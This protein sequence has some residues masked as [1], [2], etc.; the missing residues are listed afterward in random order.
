M[1]FSLVD[2][3]IKKLQTAMKP[4]KVRAIFVG[5]DVHYLLK[6]HACEYGITMSLLANHSISKFFGFD[7]PAY[8][9]PK[10]SLSESLPEIAW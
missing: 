8:E 9:I 1:L 2:T 7:M 5:N 3:F 10:K 4:K 6:R